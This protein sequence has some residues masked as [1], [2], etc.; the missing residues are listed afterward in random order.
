MASIQEKH[1]ELVKA[2]NESTT[3]A[4]HRNADCRLRGFREAMQI[5]DSH[6][7]MS[8]MECDLHYIEMGIDRP[9][10]CGVFLDWE[11]TP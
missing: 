1:L 2:V 3:I 8:L 5:T 10:C 11:P 4:E 9:M 6:Y 7:G